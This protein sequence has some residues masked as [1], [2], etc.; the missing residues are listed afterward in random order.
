MIP[1]VKILIP[2][3]LKMMILWDYPSNPSITLDTIDFHVEYFT[4]KD[5]KVVLQKSEL[6]REEVT[7]ESGSPYVNWYAYVVTSKLSSGE[8]LMRLCAHIPDINAPGGI[9]IEYTE[10]STNVILYE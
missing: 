5:T 8:L 1:Q 9:R 4:S 6:L 2:S 10:C 7:P 3:T